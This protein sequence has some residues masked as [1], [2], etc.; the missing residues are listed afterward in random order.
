ME[1]MPNISNTYYFCGI[2]AAFRTPRELKKEK[3]M[4]FYIGIDFGV[5]LDLIIPEQYNNNNTIGI[6]GICYLKCEIQDIYHGF[7]CELF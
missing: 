1:K 7:H 5:Y 3:K 4:G 6:K 2:I